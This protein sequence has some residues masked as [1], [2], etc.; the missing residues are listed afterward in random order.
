MKSIVSIL[1]ILLSVI[2]CNSTKDIGTNSNDIASKKVSDTV[3]I[4][5]DSL[6]YE[7]IIIDP[8]FSSWINGR[9]FPRGYHS[10][11]FMKMKNIRY[12]TE[13]NI[14]AQN[15]YQY[16]PNLYTMRIDYDQN[17]NYGYEVNYLIY[18][19]FIYFQNTYNQR[20]AG[21]VPNR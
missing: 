20:L 14:R 13:W 17:V 21:F 3:K 7:V 15:P 2:G 5:N 10:E 1:I 4:A 19:Y 9:A 8:G 18:N 11:N 16:D 12:V 6:E